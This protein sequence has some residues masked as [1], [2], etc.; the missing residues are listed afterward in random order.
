MGGGRWRFAR[1]TKWWWE[2]GWGAGTEEWVSL[3]PP[4][5]MTLGISVPQRAFYSVVG[6]RSDLV[7]F[8]A[9]IGGGVTVF[10]SLDRPRG[11]IGG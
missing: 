8:S 1:R 4:R 3:A 5:L 6:S 11:G 9:F 7:F 2:V 10:Y